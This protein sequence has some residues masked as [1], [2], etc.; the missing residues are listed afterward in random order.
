MNNANK[1]IIA[2]P[3]VTQTETHSHFINPN[4]AHHNHSQNDHDMLSENGVDTS[5]TP[6]PQLVSAA[7]QELP[8]RSTMNYDGAVDLESELSYDDQDAIAEEDDDDEFEITAHSKRFIDRQATRSSSQESRRA[9]KRKVVGIEDDEDIMNNPELYGIRR[10]VSNLANLTK[11][12]SD[13]T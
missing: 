8:V 3:V 10:S 2:G 7:P 9:L 4:P 12:L 1:H 6:Q 11:L 13:N 5:E